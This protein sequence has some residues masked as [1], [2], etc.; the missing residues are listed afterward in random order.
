MFNLDRFKN[1]CA[2]K[3]VKQS[4]LFALVGRPRSYGSDL[5]KIRN[6]PIEYINTWAAALHTT[7]AYLMG[8]T[9]DPGEG[10]KKRALRPCGRRAERRRSSVY[11]GVSGGFP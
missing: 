1:L 2:E 10:I 5:K 6:V 11:C 9:D 7:P 8:E 4:A 3:G